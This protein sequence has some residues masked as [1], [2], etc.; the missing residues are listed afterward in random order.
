MNDLRGFENWLSRIEGKVDKITETNFTK[1]DMEKFREDI[2]TPSRTASQETHKQVDK[3][4]FFQAKI[5]G[6]FAVVSAIWGFLIVL[7]VNKIN[8]HQ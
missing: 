4:R 1:S 7:I 5:Y 6:A 3:L 8:H 2:C